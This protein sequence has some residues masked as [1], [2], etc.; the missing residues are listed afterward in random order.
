MEFGHDRC[1]A[2]LRLRDEADPAF[3]EILTVLRNSGTPLVEIVLPDRMA[4]FGEFYKWEIATVVAAFVVQMGYMVFQLLLGNSMAASEF[5]GD[6]LIPTIALTALLSPPVLLVARRL[7]GA[8]AD[9]TG[10]GPLF[11]HRSGDGRRDFINLIDRFA[12]TLNGVDCV[13]GAG[14]DFADL[15]CNI[16]CRPGGLIGEIFYLGRDDREAFSGFTCAGGFDG[17]VQGE[18]IGLAG[19]VLD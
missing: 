16:F 10:R 1:V 3:D 14:L 6:L 13:T 9:F 15:G 8:A 19:D 17:C 5:V 4:V 11:L 18:Q 2:S 12:N 7:L